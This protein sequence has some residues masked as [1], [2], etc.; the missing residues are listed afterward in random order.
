MKTILFQGDSITDVDRVREQ[1]YDLGKGYALMTAAQLGR[2][3]PGEYQF[4]NRGISGNRVVD[5]FARWKVDCFN[6]KPD[7]ISILIGVNDVWHDFAGDE[8]ANGVDVEKYEKVYD[9]LIEETL[10]KLPGVKIVI[11]EPYVIHGPATD[12]LWDKFSGEVKLRSEVAKR[13]AKKYNL[14]FIPLQSIFDEA[15]KNAPDL[16]WSADGVHPTAQGHQLIT[17]AWIEKF[18][19]ELK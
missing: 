14:P 3:Y 18:E 8:Y 11:M 6:L 15:V 9:M 12:D 17:E 1:K 13:L 4:F 16:F 10:E 2:K 5:L 7:Y 19:S